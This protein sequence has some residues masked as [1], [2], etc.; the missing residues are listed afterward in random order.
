MRRCLQHESNSEH[1]FLPRSWEG[2]C[3]LIL[4]E[5]RKKISLCLETCGP[6]K[7][8]LQTLCVTFYIRHP[9]VKE[10]VY[11]GKGRN[12][13]FLLLERTRLQITESVDK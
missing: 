5:L 9:R 6:E 1:L 3:F 7:C 8:C 10:Q 4:E 13:T 2:V 12:I 11:H